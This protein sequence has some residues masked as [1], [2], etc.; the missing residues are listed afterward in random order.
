MREIGYCLLHEEQRSA[1]CFY[2]YHGAR[3]PFLRSNLLLGT[4]LFDAKNGLVLGGAHFAQVK[5]LYKERDEERDCH[6]WPADAAYEPRKELDVGVKIM[7][8]TKNVANKWHFYL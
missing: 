5:N 6:I 3:T 4:H 1:S 7:M 2:L 8:D